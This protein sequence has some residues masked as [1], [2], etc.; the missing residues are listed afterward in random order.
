MGS[1]CLSLDPPPPVSLDFVPAFLLLVTE[2][3]S[4]SQAWEK[5]IFFQPNYDL[6]LLPQLFGFVFA[7]APQ[8]LS[9]PSQQFRA[10]QPHHPIPALREHLGSSP[11]LWVP[12]PCVLPFL[13]YAPTDFP[14]TP[15]D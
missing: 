6:I 11:L 14:Q 8:F 4:L 1:F 12:L 13:Q 10:Y 5:N 15:P 2:M 9:C 7:L 3:L